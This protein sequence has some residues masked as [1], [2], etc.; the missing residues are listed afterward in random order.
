M[1]PKLSVIVPVYNE[2]KTLEQVLNRINAVD[3]DKEII[4]VDDSSIDKTPKILQ[5]ILKSNKLNSLKVIFHSYNQGKGAA[6]LTG[7]TYASG[8]FVII[9]DAD[10]EYD[11]SD[12]QKMFR[13]FLENNADL[14]LGARFTENYCGS[15]IPR[16]G[17][18]FLTGLLNLL[19]D[20]QVNDCFSCY[21]LLRRNTLNSF[22]LKARRFDIEIEIITKVFKNNLRLIEIPIS[23]QRRSYA[24]GK[25]IRWIDGLYAIV[26]ILH[27]RFLG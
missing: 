4:V 6:V 14:V 2:E 11:P 17:N 23:Y 13:T 12:Y 22:K 16:L 3:I 7:L 19:F 9:Q 8:E 26:S 20:K 18:R 1:P 5:D 24:E 21:K 27:Y 10:L 15:M 25:K